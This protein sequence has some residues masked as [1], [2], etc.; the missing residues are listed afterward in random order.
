MVLLKPLGAESESHGWLLFAFDFGC[1]CDGRVGVVCK[2]NDGL[3]FNKETAGSNIWRD[4][5]QGVAAPKKDATL[6]ETPWFSN[7]CIA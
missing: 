2:T 3:F 5:W 7:F 4:K 6:V 1:G